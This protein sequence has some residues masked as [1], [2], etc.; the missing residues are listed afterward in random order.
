MR[1]RA[2][3]LS[4]WT[5]IGIATAT[6]GL[7]LV[8]CQSVL[9][10]SRETILREVYV[11]SKVSAS[12]PSVGGEP[13]T[14][15]FATYAAAAT[16][17]T[18]T[19][20]QISATWRETRAF[21]SSILGRLGYG[22]GPFTWQYGHRE[23]TA[24]VRFQRDLG[25]PSTGR[26][27]S[28]TIWN[29]LEAQDVLGKA[30]IKLPYLEVRRIGQWFFA[31]G[32]WKAITNKLGYPVNIVNIECNAISGECAVTWVEFISEALDQVGRMTTRSLHVVHWD[33]D[34]LVAKSGDESN[35]TLTINVPA[36]D[37][38]WTQEAGV[39]VKWASDDEL[40]RQSQYRSKLPSD[41]LAGSAEPD[42]L[43]PQRMTLKL[44]DGSK[45]SPPQDGGD[46]KE[47]H[48]A[49]FKE[50][51]RFLALLR[52]NTHFEGAP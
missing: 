20:N 39:T 10:P 11:F 24:L 18:A 42:T 5:S 28:L 46:L 16:A 40:R 44:V 22:T 29:L 3:P 21:C 50:K 12:M 41:L 30:D 31:S 19:W 4:R 8:S 45:L 32:T 1:L 14:T 35:I 27:D 9:P 2:P 49:L 51:E 43:N 26:L 15:T 36:Q 33:K 23:R 52:K 13:D 38:T 7:A 34:M 47:V 25:I 37:V 48:D 6:L 17:D